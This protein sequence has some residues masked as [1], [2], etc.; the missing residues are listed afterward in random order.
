MTTSAHTGK[1]WWFDSPPDTYWMIKTLLKN[2]EI[3]IY[4]VMSEYF[5]KSQSKTMLLKNNFRMK[6]TL[7]W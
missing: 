3:P 6:N 7:T 4:F 1:Q 2:K 5:L